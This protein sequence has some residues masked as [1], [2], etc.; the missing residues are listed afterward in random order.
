VNASTSG[1]LGKR[2][3][4]FTGDGLTSAR[5]VALICPR[6]RDGIPFETERIDEVEFRKENLK[7]RRSLLESP[8]V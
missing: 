1:V 6:F 5:G 3:R 2:N 4:G 7:R 8:T